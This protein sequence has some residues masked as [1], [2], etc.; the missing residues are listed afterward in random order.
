MKA[1]LLLC[2]FSLLFTRMTFAAERPN[3]LYIFTDDQSVRTVGCYPDAYPWVKTPNIDALA[4]RG[5]LFHNVYMAAYCVPS[6]VS[7]LTG[8]LPHAA[9]GDFGGKALVGAALAQEEKEHPFWPRRLRDSGYRTGMIGKWHI[10]SRPPAVG[11]DWDTAIHWR[12]QREE[13]FGGYYNGQKVSINGAPPTDLEGY[14]VDRHTD[15]AVEFIKDRAKGA[16]DKPWLLWLCLCGVHAPIEPAE[17]HQG[18]LADVGPIPAPAS[19]TQR[20][21][22]PAYIR[23]MH[24]PRWDKVE[25]KI[26][27]Y[28]ECVMALDENVGRLMRTLE[29]SGQLENTVVIFAA[30]QGIAYGQHGLV[31]KKDAPYDAALR[32]PLIIRWPGHFAENQ[33]TYEPVNQTDVVRT[34][35]EIT[36]LKPLPTMDGESLVPLLEK[37]RTA[38]LRRGAMLMTNVQTQMGQEIPRMIE[39]TRRFI[40]KGGKGMEAMY[41]WT[42][43]RSGSHKYIAYAGKDREE[44]L[45]DLEKDSEELVNLAASPEQKPLLKKLRQQAAAELRKTQSGFDGGHFIDF[46]P[47]LLEAER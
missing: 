11:L 6:R 12:S 15:L 27:R 28:H 31:A 5:V 1:H 25:P 30:D 37:P 44:E 10:G 3:V 35:H 26:R 8:N 13:L 20:D 14:S 7:F 16:G 41:D 24:T 46:F 34:I 18:A 42:L 4:D 21:G 45:Y 43:I 47:L 36:A 29:E 17:R 32:G 2:L 38:K 40:E 23:D 19:F 22:K 39:R 9:Q 33:T